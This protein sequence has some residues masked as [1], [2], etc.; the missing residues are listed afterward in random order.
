MKE[1]ANYQQLHRVRCTLRHP[2]MI[3]DAFGKNDKEVAR[4]FK[5]KKG[6]FFTGFLT[7][8]MVIG[9][10]VGINAADTS[11]ITLEGSILYANGQSIVLRKDA[12]DG[13]TYVLNPSGEKL[14]DQAVGNLTIYGGSKNADVYGDIHIVIDGASFSSIHGGGYSDGRGSADVY[15]NVS[16][17]VIGNTDANTLYGGG[18]AESKYGNAAAN[19][20]G[21]IHVAV[22]AVPKGNHGNITC[23]GQAF[24]YNG[25]EAHAS[26]Q[27]N[28]QGSISG[29]TYSMR[30]GGAASIP[31]TAK[32]TEAAYADVAGDVTLSVENADIR[33]VYGGGYASSYVP[34]MAVS[35]NVNYASTTVR[36]SE[37]MILQGGG[38]ASGSAVSARVNQTDVTLNSCPNIY[39]YVRAGGTAYGGAS[40]PVK[41]AGLHIVDSIIP[42]DEQWGVIVSA[43]IYGGGSANG[44]GSDARVTSSLVNIERSETA[45][46]IYGG[47]EASSGGNADVASIHTAYRQ[48]TSTVF[49][50]NSYASALIAGGSYDGD[51]TFV[52]KQSELLVE[53]ATV[54]QLW[55]CNESGGNVAYAEGISKATI[56]G[57][58]QVENRLAG[59]DTIQMDG[60]LTAA[61]VTGKNQT[62]STQLKAADEIAVGTLLITTQNP[63]VD[64][65]IFTLDNGVLTCT[66]DQ[67]VVSWK[68]AQMKY[69]IKT[70]AGPNG[71]ITK[72]FAAN[73]LN[74]VTVSWKT[75][76]SYIVDTVMIDGVTMD[77]TLTS[78][79]FE[80]LLADHTVSVT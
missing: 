43:G 12:A 13:L 21:S 38:E 64:P 72:S 50:G 66:V 37:I 42:A 45:G 44:S 28:V 34:G 32:G 20:N 35:A 1:Y 71:T 17:Q 30:G 31:S 53:Q 39:G 61:D 59:F 74:T 7:I 69:S 10:F 40:A 8:L 68:V 11:S 16:I 29:R 79:T 19:V 78:Y 18:Y 77:S 3:Q 33:E 57:A 25:Y 46:T 65:F 24:A 55:G 14:L 67:G 4:M 41:E 75:D 15:G 27:G 76:S 47:G 6:K 70:S 58:V 54:D 36:N 80:K 52:S 56:I 2:V 26:V 51:S 73:K 62:Q 48:N 22:S 9:S 49:Q 60:F 63:D 23:G 5:K